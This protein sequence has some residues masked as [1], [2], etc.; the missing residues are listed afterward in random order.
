MAQIKMYKDDFFSPFPPPLPAFNHYEE[1][2]QP[3]LMVL[4]TRSSL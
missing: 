4:D 3:K 2:W 1:S